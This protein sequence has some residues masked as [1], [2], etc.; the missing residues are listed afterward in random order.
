M[1]DCQLTADIIGQVIDVIREVLFKGTEITV[2]KS[3]DGKIV[4]DADR[5]AKFIAKRRDEYMREFLKEFY[6]EWSEL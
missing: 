6:D 3:I 2:S 4:Q 5:C 1:A